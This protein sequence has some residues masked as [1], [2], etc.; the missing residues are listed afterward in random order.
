MKKKLFCLLFALL[1][2][3]TAAGCGMD[4]EEERP[5]GGVEILP[6]ASPIATPDMSDGEVRD[7]DGV[8]GNGEQNTIVPSPSPSPMPTTSP[9]ASPQPTTA[10][11]ASPNR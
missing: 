6:E 5:T 4:R 3:L 11:S 1:L 8:I 2:S 9:S 7:H 10:P